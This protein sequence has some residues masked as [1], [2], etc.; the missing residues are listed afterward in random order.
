MQL[1]W[2]GWKKYGLDLV[3]FDFFHCVLPLFNYAVKICTATKSCV[4]IKFIAFQKFAKQ[5][6]GNLN[7]IEPQLTIKGL[8]L[9]SYIKD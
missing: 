1:N 6:M 9:K 5:I 7:L 3:N 8:M 4:K 2:S